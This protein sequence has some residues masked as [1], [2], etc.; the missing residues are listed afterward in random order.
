MT[1]HTAIDKLARTYTEVDAQ[2]TEADEWYERQVAAAARAVDEAAGAVEAAQRALDTATE[3]VTRIDAEAE[4]VWRTTV[5]RLGPPAAR[6]A[7]APPPGHPH[8]DEEY[9]PDQLIAMASELLDKTWRPGRMPQAAF[10]TLVVL[11]ALGAA[12]AFALREAAL[13]AG[14]SYG[15]DLAVGLPVLALVVTLVAPFVGLWPARVVADRRHVSL[16]A[17]T[18]TVVLT[19]GLAT[20]VALY[21]LT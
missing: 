14:R 8:T 4:E 5:R 15:G 12:V 7:A 6:Y 18:I 3:L 1:Y 13:W 10:P 19:T 2:R 21:L 17:T 16:D 11:S 20:T 9:D